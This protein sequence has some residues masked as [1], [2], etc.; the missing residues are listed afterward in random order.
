MTAL[1]HAMLAIALDIPNTLGLG[2][3]TTTTTTQTTTCPSNRRN[4]VRQVGA[5]ASS[6]PHANHFQGLVKGIPTILFSGATISSAL[7][8]G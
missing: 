3:K 4:D 6:R 8:V 1:L 5:I 2:N 7:V